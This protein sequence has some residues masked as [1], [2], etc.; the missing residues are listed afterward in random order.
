MIKILVAIALLLLLAVLIYI[1][2]CAMVYIFQEIWATIKK[3]K[4]RIKQ[5][6]W[7]LEW[8]WKLWKK[9]VLEWIAS[10]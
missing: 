2:F 5:S 4:R 6:I 7:D 3:A 10:L 9:G 1:L 8:E